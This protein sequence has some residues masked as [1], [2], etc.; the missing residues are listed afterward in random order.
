VATTCPLCRYRLVLDLKGDANQKTFSGDRILVS[1]FI[2]DFGQPERWDVIVFKYPAGHENQYCSVPACS[3]GLEGCGPCPAAECDGWANCGFCARP[4]DTTAR[5]TITITGF[6]DGQ[7][8]SCTG[9]QSRGGAALFLA[10]LL[11]LLRRRRAPRRR[12]PI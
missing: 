5:P 1:K 11:R 12:S 10:A 6:D 9:S 2:Y 8:C 4:E 3:E 7:G